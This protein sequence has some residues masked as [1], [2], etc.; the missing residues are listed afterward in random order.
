MSTSE[1]KK[2]WKDEADQL[3]RDLGNRKKIIKKREVEI[4]FPKNK[5]EFKKSK[6][7]PPNLDQ[8]FKN[9]I[10]FDA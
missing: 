9:Q 10:N 4:K 5:P 7:L 8:L 3:K 2:R 6:S 1:D